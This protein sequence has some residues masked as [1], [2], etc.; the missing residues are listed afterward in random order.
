MQLPRPCSAPLALGLAVASWLLAAAPQA[1]AEERA[2]LLATT[3]SV[4]DSGLL[5]LLLPGFERQSGRAVRVVAVGSGAALRMGADGNADVVIAHAPEAEQE[6][7]ASGALAKRTPFMENYF[8]IV[9]PPEDP[10]G[11]RSAAT[12]AD[13]M[14]RLAAAK[15]LYVSRGD[16]SGTHQREQALMRAA[17][18]DPAAPWSSVLRTGSGMGLTLQVAGEKRGYALS[19]LG[20]FLAF[21]ERIGLAALT[22]EAPDLRNVYSLL[23]VPRERHPRVD[24]AGAAA[25]ERFLTQ[26]EAQ[27]R[28]ARFG[29]EKY[30]QA[31]FRPL[32]G[33]Q[34]AADPAAPDGARAAP[35]DAAPSAA[36]R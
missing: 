10:A 11:V 25:L 36:A 21:R 13:A 20:T 8:A 7:L 2:L 34:G 14:R 19:D 22:R 28:I 5:D 23:R 17:G 9:G 30:G 27:Q 16:D 15:A 3:T 12:G 4:Q 35:P 18:L 33:T 32:S 6:L 24:D 1:M 26:P 29:V 31:L